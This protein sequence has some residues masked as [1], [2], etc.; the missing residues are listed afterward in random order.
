MH[1]NG[2]HCYDTRKDITK[3]AFMETI[4]GNKKGF[5]KRKIKGAEI[6]KSLYTTLSYPSVKDYKWAI[7]SNQINNCQVTVEDVATASK[8]WERM[9]THLKARPRG[10]NRK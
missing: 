10:V 3:F 5:T 2:M 9:S 4:V 1:A 6:A 7:H 8:I